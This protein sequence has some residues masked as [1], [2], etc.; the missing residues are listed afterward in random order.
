MFHYNIAGRINRLNNLE[1]FR[2]HMIYFTKN[3]AI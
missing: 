1:C 3:Y 2:F